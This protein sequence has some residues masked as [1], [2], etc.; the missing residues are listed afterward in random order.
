MKAYCTY[1]TEAIYKSKLDPSQSPITS[2]GLSEY[3]RYSFPRINLTFIIFKYK[4]N[5]NGYVYKYKYDQYKYKQQ[6]L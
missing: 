2:D 6:R 3:K 5:I 4:L 1:I